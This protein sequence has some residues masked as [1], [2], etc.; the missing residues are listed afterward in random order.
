M[1]VKPNVEARSCN[2]CHRR[3][4]ISITYS[5]FVFELL[6]TQHAMRK[7]HIVICR[8]SDCTILFQHYLIYGKI[9]GK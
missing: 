1:Y 5:E 3:K 4:S 9:F 2:H 6:V 8:L 7:F